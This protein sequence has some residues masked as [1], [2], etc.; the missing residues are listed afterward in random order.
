M[1]KDHPVIPTE[2]WI[3]E[4]EQVDESNWTVDGQGWTAWNVMSPEKEFCDFAAALIALVRPA[5]VIETGVG[6]GYLTRRILPRLPG[7]YVGYESNDDLR[8]KLLELEIWTPEAR[9]SEDVGPTPEAIAACDLAIFDSVVLERK[10]EVDLW[11]E[12]AH[13]GAY[14]LIHDARPDHPSKNGLHRKAAEYL[15]DK[16][17]F[18]GNPRG[19]WLYRKPL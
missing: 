13:A 2:A 5:L 15:G 14:V 10:R 16:G 18:L 11:H 9:L 1:S 17:I 12:H 8:P 3:A 7:R 19:C 4:S 6:Q